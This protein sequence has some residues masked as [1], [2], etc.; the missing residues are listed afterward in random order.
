MSEVGAAIRR[1]TVIFMGAAGAIALALG[2]ASFIPPARDLPRSEVGQRVLP[3]FESKVGSVALIMVSTEEESYHLVRNAD[4]WVLPEKGSYPVSAARIQDLTQALGAITYA[5]AMTRDDRKFDR[6]GLGDPGAGGAGALLE[7]SDG[8]GNSFAKLIVGHRDGRSYVR[9]PDDLQAWAVGGSVL[10]PLQRGARWLD[11]D[12][13]KIDPAGILEADVRPAEGAPY[14]L[15]RIDIGGF[16]LAPPY[17][18]RLVLAAM[19]PSMVA[20][21]IAR[22][23]PVDVTPALEVAVGRPLAEH[24]TRTRDGVAIVVRS[25]RAKERGWVTVSAATAEGATPAAV[26]MAMDLNTRTAPWAFALSELDWG[27][28]STPLNAIAE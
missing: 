14:R 4:G 3:A 20:E 22:F 21:A 2:A 16:G 6:I 12:V 7:V 23:A 8:N 17:D 15:N 5:E 27:A 18:K 11:L 28:F 19:G 25:W 26:Q 1:K 24:I 9:K 13:V 10:P